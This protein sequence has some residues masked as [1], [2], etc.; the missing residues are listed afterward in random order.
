MYGKMH[1]KSTQQYC[2]KSLCSAVG[3]EIL[4]FTA[5][6]LEEEMGVSVY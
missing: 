1:V 4:K 2:C 6:V 5:R 3:T